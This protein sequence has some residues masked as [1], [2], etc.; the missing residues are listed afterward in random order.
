MSSPVIES[1]WMQMHLNAIAN[2]NGDQM[3]GDVL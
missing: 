1:N 2:Q 3:E